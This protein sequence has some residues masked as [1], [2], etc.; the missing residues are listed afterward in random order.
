M[1]YAAF[2]SLRNGLIL[3]LLGI[4]IFAAGLTAG[5]LTMV[6]VPPAAAPA[7]LPGHMTPIEPQVGKMR[8][9]FAIL[10]HIGAWV[11]VAGIG[12]SIAGMVRRKK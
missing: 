8:P 1:N 11:F 2:A 10:M 9:A 4:G 3:V 12:V 5:L 6:H 7:E